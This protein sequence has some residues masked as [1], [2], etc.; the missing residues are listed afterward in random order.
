M[1]VKKIWHQWVW[2]LLIGFVVVGIFFPA[3]GTIALL[4]MLAPVVTAFWKGRK[5]CGYY[6]PRGSFNDYLLSK[7]TLKRG[8]PQI[9]KEPWFSLVF[10]VLL[11]GAF[12]IQILLAWGSLVA[13]GAVFVRMVLL[14]TLLGIIMGIIFNYRAWCMICPMG[15]LASWVVKLKLK[16]VNTR[17]RQVRF[18]AEQCIDCKL[19]SHCCPMGIDVAAY[20]ELGRVE[21]GNC[22]QCRVC[23]EKC[24]KQAL[25]IQWHIG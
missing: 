16:K 5:W 23:I 4:C 8:I 19:C 2:L 10:L 11:M 6:C 25:F 18:V 15:T 20:R 24:P 12:L 22:L 17:L 14:T 9:I 13:I 21:D 7:I 1:N 3:I